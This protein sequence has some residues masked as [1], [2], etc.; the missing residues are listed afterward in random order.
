MI[1]ILTSL[2]LMGYCGGYA[3]R[4]FRQQNPAAGWVLSAL[5]LANAALLAWLVTL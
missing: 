2:A 1:A 3:A 4:Q 5:C